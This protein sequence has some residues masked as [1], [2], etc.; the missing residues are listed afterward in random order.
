MID[1]FGSMKVFISLE[2]KLVREIFILLLGAFIGIACQIGLNAHGPNLCRSLICSSDAI[3]YFPP[4]RICSWLGGRLEG[5]RVRNFRSSVLILNS[6]IYY[7][8]KV[9]AKTTIINIS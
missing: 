1:R 8:Y 9:K 2:I 6:L 7:C 4:M 3:G 5:S